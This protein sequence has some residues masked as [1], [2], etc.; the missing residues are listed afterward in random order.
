METEIQA[1]PQSGPS[2]RESPSP[3]VQRNVSTVVRAKGPKSDAPRVP[4]RKSARL[5]E[6]MKPPPSVIII[7][8]DASKSSRRTV[9]S[10]SWIHKKRIGD[11]KTLIGDFTF[12]KERDTLIT[13]H[14]V[15]TCKVH[16]ERIWRDL[17]RR[18]PDIFKNIS[19][20]I[21][22]VRQLARGLASAY[23]KEHYK[24]ELELLKKLC[25]EKSSRQ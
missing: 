23:H 7:S 20:D 6:K 3:A 5:A 18:N 12:T 2:W 9:S 14:A 21:L 25:I 16:D 24:D 4:V 17:I 22:T 19:P 15:K 11:V 8:P 13:T 10:G 1:K